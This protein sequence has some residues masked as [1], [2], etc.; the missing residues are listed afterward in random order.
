M[1][2]AKPKKGLSPSEPPFK[3]DIEREIWRDRLGGKPNTVDNKSEKSIF[4]SA[5][6]PF[7]SHEPSFRQEPLVIGQ[8]RVAK[9]TD[10]ILKAAPELRGKAKRILMGPS[11]GIIERLAEEDYPLRK[12]ETSNL[13]GITEGK[14]DI[15]INPR[16]Y[17]EDED[18][19]WETLGHELAHTSGSGHPEAYTIGEQTAETLGKRKKK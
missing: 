13:L 17:K 4:A 14:K 10:K 11:N 2:L 16:L 7:V 1:P 19:L 9:M 18:F 15:G 3:W 6:L 8:P 5:D 12:F